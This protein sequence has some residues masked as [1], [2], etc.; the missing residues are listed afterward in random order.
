MKTYGLNNS[1]TL[2]I[3]VKWIQHK[4]NYRQLPYT[5]DDIIIRSTLAG[6]EKHC[7]STVE[8]KYAVI[9]HELDLKTAEAIVTQMAKICWL[10]PF[11]NIA[12]L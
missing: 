10:I 2:Y 5:E 4:I 12:C 3:S 8:S 1:D 9:Q 7:V 6:K 11:K